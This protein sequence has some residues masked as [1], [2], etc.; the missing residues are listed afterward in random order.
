MTDLR[1]I[2]PPI[3]TPFTEDEKLDLQALRSNLEIWTQTPL[4]GV[5]TPGSNSEL[6]H[7]EEVEKEQLWRTCRIALEATGKQLIVG[8]GTATTRESIKLTKQAADLGARAALV[9]TPHF[10]T[11]LMTQDALMAHFTAVADSSP[12]DII[13][14]NVP[15]FTGVVLQPETILALADHP[16][17]TG[18]K[19]SSAH[20]VNMS[21]VLSQKPDFLVFSGSGSALL[22][23]LSIGA[24]GGIMALANIAPEMLHQMTQ[25]FQAGNLERARKTQLQLV[26]LNTAITSKYG[27]PGLKY[28]MDQ[29]GMTGGSSRRP[30]Q[31]LSPQGKEEIEDLITSARLKPLA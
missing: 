15:Q 13:L 19:D 1:G 12:I 28:A 23:L 20:L 17:I 22:P 29:L 10:Y 31:P 30:L 11:P 21:R 4:A 25:D 2:Y 5:V 26:N 3:P 8:T 14:Y 7:L 9:I 16:R 18:I 24:S 27:I 6:P